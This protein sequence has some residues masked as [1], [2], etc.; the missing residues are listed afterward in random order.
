MNS[1]PE[2][3]ISTINEDMTEIDEFETNIMNYISLLHPDDKLFLNFK[4]IYAEGTQYIKNYNSDDYT[5]YK[6][7]RDSILSTYTT[8]KE[9]YYLDI[10]NE[11]V[12]V[13]KIKDSKMIENLYQLSNLSLVKTLKKPKLINNLDIE[14]DKMKKNIQQTRY[15]LQAQYQRLVNN[16]HLD[17]LTKENFIKK[18]N[19]FSKKI[20]EYYTKLYYFHKVNGILTSN[21][22]ILLNKLISY[23]PEDSSTPIP[24]LSSKNI[25]I[26]PEIISKLNGL[27]SENLNNYYQVLQNLTNKE[28][29]TKEIKD[30]IKDYLK[31]K[32]NTR[33]IDKIIDKKI[34]IKIITTLLL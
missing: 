17:A 16:I 12:N 30:S 4:N 2:T 31:N 1:T 23:F 24:R 27:E 33:D 21:E 14:L 11:E 19:K 9:K 20:N 28:L 6:K 5:I 18:R 10:T 15:K 34:N 3:N 22:N 13:F 25:N 26:T 7:E 32:K 8:K 29:K